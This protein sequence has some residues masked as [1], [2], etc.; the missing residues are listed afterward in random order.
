MDFIVIGFG[1]KFIEYPMHCHDSWEILFNIEGTGVAT[2]GDE[3]YTFQPG[4]IFCIRPG[5][6]HGKYAKDGFLDG[7]ILI[8]D[9]CFKNEHGDVFVFQDDERNSLYELYKIALN[10]SMDPEIGSFGEKFLTSLM[11]A[12]QNLLSK[13]KFSDVKN[14]EVRYIQNVLSEHVS[15]FDFD[16]ESLLESSSYSK[17]YIR[18]LFKEQCGYTPV[19]YY[20]RLKV[21]LAK[22]L[23][24]QKKSTLSI[25]E[26]ALACGIADPYYFSRLFKKIEGCS[27]MM[28]YKN[29][30][31]TMKKPTP[32]IDIE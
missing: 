5:V 31:I 30:K 21:I 7:G 6:M 9:F 3:R 23:I 13:W 11:D 15:D 2:I 19:Q 28:F 1:K 29:S 18:K 24:L 16:L 8:N 27:P 20:N 12:I 14:E 4:T 22:Q 10:Y 32:E 17:N 25:G 26:I